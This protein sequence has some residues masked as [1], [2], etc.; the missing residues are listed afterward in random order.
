MT[1]FGKIQN[2]L[3]RVRDL[4]QDL[5]DILVNEGHAEV[6]Y[7]CNELRN[8]VLLIEEAFDRES[9]QVDLNETFNEVS[10]NYYR[11]YPPRGGLTE[12]FIWREDFDERLKANHLLDHI[13]NELNAILKGR[14]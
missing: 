3:A 9:N 7:A 1:D 11:M 10:E 14:S 6:H 13:K 4:F 8:N 2:D 5:L 12:F